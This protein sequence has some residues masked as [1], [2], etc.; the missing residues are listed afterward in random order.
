MAIEAMIESSFNN[1]I[2]VCE[3]NSVGE[4]VFWY[5]HY[6]CAKETGASLHEADDA[7]RDRLRKDYV[8]REKV[9]NSF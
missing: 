4:H 5:Q 2:I 8:Y 7:L 3:K 9:F 6:P 1:R